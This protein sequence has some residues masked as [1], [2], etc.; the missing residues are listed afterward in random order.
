MACDQLAIVGDHAGHCPA[1]LGHAR[2][3]FCHLVVAMHL[4]IAGIGAQPGN[5]PGLNLA[6]REDEVHEVAFADGAERPGTC[7][8]PAGPAAHG[9]RDVGK[10]KTPA[11]VPERMSCRYAIV[12]QGCQMRDARIGLVICGNPGALEARFKGIAVVE[13]HTVAHG[14][15]ERRRFVKDRICVW[16]AVSVIVACHA[17]QPSRP[18]LMSIRR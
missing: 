13:H 15:H 7:H 8:R 17:A 16:P 18:N 2:G 1:E 11:R 3:D 12:Q 9:I 5:R 6:R 14:V 4:G 10:T